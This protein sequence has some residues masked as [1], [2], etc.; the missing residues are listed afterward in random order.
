METPSLTDIIAGTAERGMSE[1]LL[2][3]ADYFYCLGAGIIPPPPSVPGRIDLLRTLECLHRI[4]VL[5]P[6]GWLDPP[7]TDDDLPSWYLAHCERHAAL[8][9]E[10][11][12][13]W[14]RGAHNEGRP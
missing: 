11:P 9:T 14:I 13:D 7:A 4:E 6:R 3:I 10:R 1:L 5:G 2:A 8:E 12:H